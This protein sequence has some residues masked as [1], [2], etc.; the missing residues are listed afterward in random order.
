MN[1]RGE[2]DQN[3]IPDAT[4]RGHVKLQ[5][6]SL[7]HGAKGIKGCGRR[8]IRTASTIQFRKAPML[9]RVM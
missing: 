5:H 4:S 3:R 2:S 6:Y 1:I 9:F 7:E 8:T